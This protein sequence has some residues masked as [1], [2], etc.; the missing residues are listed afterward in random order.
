MTIKV[1]YKTSICTTRIKIPHSANKVRLVNSKRPKKTELKNPLRFYVYAYLR[2]KDSAT[3]KAGTPYYIGKGQ[4]NRARVE[5]RN[6]VKGVHT[7]K[8][9]R[10]IV[11][12]ETNLSDCGALALER[13]YIRW[14]GRKDN[15]TGILLNQTHGG[16]GGSGMIRSKESID[17]QILR[18]TGSK[19]SEASKKKSSI[20]KLGNKNPMFGKIQTPEHRLKNSIANS[21]DRNAR[22]MLGKT[23]SKESNQKRSD[24][25]KGNKSP[26]FGKSNN[27]KDT[28]LETITCPICGVVG[29]IT[30]MRR[31]HFE[32]CGT[33]IWEPWNAKQ[34]INSRQHIVNFYYRFGEIYD[35]ICTRTFTSKKMMT[36]ELRKLLNIDKSLYNALSSMT[37]HIV[38]GLNPYKYDS[39]V[40][41]N[42]TK[43]L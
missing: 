14:Y 5:H 9:N 12:L 25:L 19:R 22:G 28:T 26:F 18:Q 1:N 36:I 35:Y 6:D 43:H 30:G 10:Y 3:G 24:A 31:Y 38:D 15:D 37:L 29:S 39:W 27:L 20:S 16:E 17:M 2:N 34:N 11:F 33:R 8:D 7:P 13:F 21:G 40:K 32:N 41:F 4:G 23:Q 42:N